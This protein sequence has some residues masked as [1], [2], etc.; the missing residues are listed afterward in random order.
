MTYGQDEA[1]SKFE[2]GEREYS[3]PR[4]QNDALKLR[5]WV[6][7]IESPML[8]SPEDQCSISSLP[9]SSSSDPKAIDGVEDLLVKGV[10]SGVTSSMIDSSSAEDMLRARNDEEKSKVGMM[11]DASGVCSSGVDGGV[12]VFSTI[13]SSAHHPF[14]ASPITSRTISFVHPLKTTWRDVGVKCPPGP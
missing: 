8:S 9:K 13:S 11:N 12:G 2:R 4:S 6:V 14:P 5:D 1:Q 10:Q 3:A 7:E